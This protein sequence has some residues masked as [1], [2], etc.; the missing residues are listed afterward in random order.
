M[1]FDGA[2]QRA[3]RPRR[4]RGDRVVLFAV[5]A[6]HLKRVIID[7]YFDGTLSQA[8]DGLGHE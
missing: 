4:G 3:E 6:P 5:R 7:C 8:E 1:P 2:L